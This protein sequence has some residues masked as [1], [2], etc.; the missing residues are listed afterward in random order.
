M[1]ECAIRLA[2][3]ADRA[4]LVDLKWELNRVEIARM[5]VEH[6]LKADR[7]TAR[8]AA[9]AGV[10]AYLELVGA[11]DGEILVAEHGGRVVGSLCWYPDL[12][13][14]S[15]VESARRHGYITGFAVTGDAR[16]HGI[17]SQLMAEAERRIRARG[18]TRMMLG[19]VAWN[20]ETI[21]FYQRAGFLPLAVSMIKPLG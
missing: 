2:M 20:A 3:P 15:I 16:G 6:A 4:A 5:P 19:V 17:G 10:A 9:D 8:A 18:L 21:R 7:D 14:P 1:P 13:S 12:G 11:R